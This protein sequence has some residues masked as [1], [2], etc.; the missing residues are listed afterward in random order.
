MVSKFDSRSEHVIL[1]QEPNMEVERIPQQ[2]QK[3]PTMVEEDMNPSWVFYVDVDEPHSFVEALNGEDSQH[4]KKAMDSKFQFSQD[5][6]TRILTFF[7]FDCK[8][9]NC[10]WIFK[11]KYNVNGSLVRHK[12]NLVASGFT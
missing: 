5:N 10:K 4:W 8:P 12:A 6:K 7:P 1:N 11:I 3:N 9:M 2:M